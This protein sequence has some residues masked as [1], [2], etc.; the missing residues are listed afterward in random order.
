MSNDLRQALRMVY[1]N[2][3]FSSVAILTLALGIGANTALFSVA[4]AVLL[5][6]LP[7][8]DPD[9]IVAV[10]GAPYRFGPMITGMV[11][12][13]EQSPAFHGI[14]LYA[15]GAV[16]IGGEPRAER[17]RAAAVSHGFFPALGASPMTGRVFTADDVNAD[18]Y[19]AVLGHAL[20]RR[21][22]GGQPL[23]DRTTILVNGRAYAVL[24][25]MP[26]RYDFPGRAEI[27]IPAGADLQI[28][29]AAFAPQTIA[30]LAPG[31]TLDHARAEIQRI[32]D[33][34]ARRRG[35][36]DESTVTVAPF[37][38]RLV[39]GVRPLILTV[40]AAVLL[41]L[42]VA[43]I[44]TANLL[45]AR[46]S[47]RE[48]EMSVRRALGASRGRLIRH[49]LVESAVLSALAGLVALPAAMWTLDGIRV[50]VPPT[51]HGS[52]EI[53][54]DG[55]AFAA[56]GTL[57]ILA[58]IL[59]GLAPAVSLRA[60]SVDALR[61]SSS[62]VVPFWRRFR[63]ALVVAEL[64]IA[65]VLLSGAAT[66][67]RT[68]SSLMRVDLGAR[69]DRAL[70]MELTLPAARYPGLPEMAAF[71]DALHPRLRALPGVE[72]AAAGSTVP[73]S[74]ETGIG[75]PIEVEGRPAPDASARFASYVTVTPEYFRALGIDVIAGRPFAATDSAGAPP[76]VMISESAARAV[77]LDPRSAIGLRARP[78]FSR[79]PSDWA[80][81]VG[82]V[83]DVRFRGPERAAGSQLYAPL[84]QRGA[85]GT[86][87]V[88]LKATGPA[89]LAPALREAVRAIDPDL[90]PYNIR[91]FDEIRGTYI[92]DRRF[93]MALMSGF[94]ALAAALAAIG[95]YGV[96][97]Y[98]VQLRTREIGIRMALGATPRAIGRQ[99]LRAG[100]LHAGGGLVAGTAAAAA[101]SR[102]L[103]SRVPGIQ[104]VD[105]GTLAIVGLVMT[106]MALC[107]TWI[108]AR[109]ATRI[110]PVEA[111]R[112]E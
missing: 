98:L 32:N 90:P 13:V 28:T 66:I 14:G 85:W 26:P 54:I 50:L 97:S 53:A 91:T 21:R 23:T 71:H 19:V 94:A 31:I 67:V 11:R 84:A 62:T 76:V 2:P 68:V 104:P 1:R 81:I 8:A 9:R 63:S 73:G 106:A 51:F 112:I 16:N 37:R 12:E 77:G 24:G 6:P 5:R 105:L 33:L 74:R 75:V 83:R 86:T 43:C 69:G 25:V 60:S 64:A 55:R 17:V 38:D 109:R 20:W 52:G 107:T 15:P 48:R 35:E 34:R 40:S 110:D 7:Y 3:G 80:T 41:V 58:T 88:V 100:V 39:G 111:L 30:R 44:N 79:S 95:L 82:V 108:P 65:L 92:A 45:L 103:I 4:D 101:F 47:A 87:F 57:S 59:F 36:T 42:L 61:G 10:D 78:P 56:T 22:F 49:L 70:A 72:A 29:G 102:V 46:V 18:R 27:W 89:R 96:I 99:M 93:A